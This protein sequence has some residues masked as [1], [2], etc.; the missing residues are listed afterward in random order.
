MPYFANARWASTM[1]GSLSKALKTM[2]LLECAGGLLLEAHVLGHPS[3]DFK[4]KRK[5]A[6]LGAESPLQKLS[7]PFSETAGPGASENGHES[8]FEGRRFLHNFA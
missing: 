4:Q 7:M 5:S 2:L 1:H 6:I 8:G 3:C